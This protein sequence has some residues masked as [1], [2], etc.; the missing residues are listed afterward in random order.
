[1]GRSKKYVEAPLP[2]EIKCHGIFVPYDASVLDKVLSND[3]K[4]IEEVK[5]YLGR[6]MEPTKGND[7][8]LG[9]NNVQNGIIVLIPAKG[10]GSDEDA[11]R[12]VLDAYEGIGVQAMLA[13]RYVYADGRYMQ[14]PYKGFLV[15]LP[16]HEIETEIRRILDTYCHSWKANQDPKLGMLYYE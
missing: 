9:V 4:D 11:I 5:D 13:D 12:Q 16:S 7:N 14:E 8:V 15:P 3:E 1:M 6:L 10:D 2:F